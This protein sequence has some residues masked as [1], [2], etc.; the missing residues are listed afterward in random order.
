MFQPRRLSSFQRLVLWTT[1][2]TY[3][4]ILVGGL[5]RASGA[6]LGCPDWPRCFGSWMPPASAAELPPQFD[7]SLFNPTLMW[8]E[9]LN[10]LLGVTVG[11]LIVATV[12]SA[13]RHHRREPRILWT[14][15][16]AL[17]LT[18]FQGWLGGRVVANELAAWVVTVHMIVALVIVQL[19]LYATVRAWRKA[20]GPPSPFL[21]ALILV[22][23]IQIGLGT[24]VRGALD[25]AID[26]GVAR[27][28]ALA[29]VGPLDHLH[30]DGALVVFAGSLLIVMWLWA[31]LPKERILIRWAYAVAGLATLQVAL[32]VVMA[33]VSLEPAPQVGHLTVASLLLGA[34]TVLLLL[35]PSIRF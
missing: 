34:E 17:L 2:S 10:R 9:Y 6:G 23:M 25:V 5:V 30:R 3:F 11:L 18:G 22:T 26:S 28:S 33:Y 16:A 7:P 35:T 27:A 8:T 24:Q 14:T 21:I 12:I 4:L 31:R 15:V 1:A 19:L 13:W 29:S 32:G 20:G